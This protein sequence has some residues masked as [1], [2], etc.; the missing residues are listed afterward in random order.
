MYRLQTRCRAI[1]LIWMRI[2]RRHSV[3]SREQDLRSPSRSQL[4]H[5]RLHPPP[6]VKRHL[7][8]FASRPIPTCS[9]HYLNLLA[10]Q[11]LNTVNMLDRSLRLHHSLRL[12]LKPSPSHRTR[13]HR[14]RDRS[15]LVVEGRKRTRSG[16][17]GLLL[18][19]KEKEPREGDLNLKF[20]GH[21]LL[22]QRTKTARLA[23][24]LL[25]RRVQDLQA[26]RSSR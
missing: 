26:P 12:S 8:I 24:R 22:V 4:R 16:I 6:Q 20:C 18:N 2:S 25:K 13:I 19:Q 7:L 10:H 1:S 15:H 5:L 9:A 3:K 11:Y 23:R 21:V 14:P 17:N